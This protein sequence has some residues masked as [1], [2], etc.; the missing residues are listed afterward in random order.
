MQSVW[1][2]GIIEFN[3]HGMRHGERSQYAYSSSEVIAPVELS[4][5]FFWAK[6]LR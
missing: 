1:P 2:T 3:A 5:P 6:T 4:I